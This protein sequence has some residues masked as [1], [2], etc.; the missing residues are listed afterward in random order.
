[1]NKKTFQKKWY[2]KLLQVIFWGSLIFLSIALMIASL[3]EDD[4]PLAGF[5]WI[6]VLIFVYWFTKRIFYHK[7]FGEK[8]LPKENKKR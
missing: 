2:Y 6:G 7:L 1:M 8:I 3:F 5:F 4:I